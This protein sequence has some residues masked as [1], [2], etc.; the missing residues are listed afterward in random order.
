MDIQGLI[1]PV[2]GEA[3]LK[4]KVFNGVL[5]VTTLRKAATLL[6]IVAFSVLFFYVILIVLLIIRTGQPLYIGLPGGQGTF[7]GQGTA[8]HK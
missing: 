3:G 2:C 7:N 5:Q 1:F 6:R 4:A 8:G